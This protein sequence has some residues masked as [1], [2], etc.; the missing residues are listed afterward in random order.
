MKKDPLEESATT[1]Q[2]ISD[3]KEQNQEVVEAVPV[4]RREVYENKNLAEYMNKGYSDSGAS[5]EKRAFKAF[6]HDSGSAHEDIE[7][8]NQTLRKRSRSAY[9]SY[10]IAASAIKTNRTHVIGRGLYPHPR[11]D[12]KLLG[13]SPEEADEWQ[14][15]VQAEFDLWASDKESCDSTGVNDFYA[16]QQLVL[17]SWLLSGDCLVQIKH[18][19]PYPMRPYSL[20]LHIIEAD[21]CSTPLAQGFIDRFITTGKAENGNLIYD[22]VEVDRNGKI[23]AYHLCNHHPFEAAIDRDGVKLE[24]VRIPA[25]G[26]RTGLPNILHIMDAD[27]P[28]QY[29]GKPYLSEV[30]ENIINLGRYEESEIIAAVLESYL[31]TV[32]TT[33]TPTTENPIQSAVP[34]VPRQTSDEVSLG[35]GAALALKPGEDIKTIDPKRPNSGFSN[36][37]KAESTLIGAALELPRDILLKEFDSSY[38]ASRGALLEAWS[39]FRMRREWFVKDFLEPVYKAFLSE[40]IGRGRIKAPGFFTD[41]LIQKAYLGC[42]WVGPSAGQLDPVKEV[43]AAKMAVSEG[44]MTHEDATTMLNGGSWDRNAERLKI[45]TQ[46]LNNMAPDP[47]QEGSGTASQGKGVSENEDR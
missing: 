34:P 42:E 28:E 16:M 20:R 31:T 38:S 39:G 19:K 47:H 43:T 36:F 18:Y 26:P 7:F 10:A 9:M 1:S 8:N 3:S 12:Q 25:I 22:G 33:Q 27:R 14:K 46:I 29:R 40:A 13:L 15:K 6:R 32:I 30:L 5:Y 23:V 24:W 2:L 17:M 4:S 45:E 11:I 44:F 35:P 21:R 41:P 37:V